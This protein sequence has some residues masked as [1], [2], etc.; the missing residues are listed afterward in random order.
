[1]L[2]IDDASYRDAQFYPKDLVDFARNLNAKGKPAPGTNQLPPERQRCEG[3]QPCLE[4]GLWFTPAKTDSQQVYRQ[5][6]K[7]PI[8]NT[9][10]GTTIWYWVQGQV[11]H[12]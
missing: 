7:I 12:M 5:G 6:D 4:T 8:Y 10:Y 9:D 3:G 1:M 2:D 11:R